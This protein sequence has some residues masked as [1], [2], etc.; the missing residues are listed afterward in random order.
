MA[1][2]YASALYVGVFLLALGI[3]DTGSFAGSPE[4]DNMPEKTIPQGNDPPGADNGQPILPPTD[5][6]EVIPPP[7]TGDEEIYTQAPN[8][9]AGHEEEVIPPPV[10]DGEPAVPPK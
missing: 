10:P 2:V 9:S 6:Q 7:P 4:A 1:N 8:P 3:G 5:D